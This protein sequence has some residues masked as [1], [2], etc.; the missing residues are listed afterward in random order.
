MLVV[1]PRRAKKRV[2]F[3]PFDFLR[4]LVLVLHHVKSGAL[5]D[6]VDRKRV[7]TMCFQTLAGVEN[8]HANERTRRR[9]MRF[10]GIIVNEYDETT[11]RPRDGV[12]GDFLELRQTVLPVPTGRA[13]GAA[14]GLWVP[15][16]VAHE[17]GAIKLLVEFADLNA[18]TFQNF[19]GFFE[20]HWPLPPNSDPQW[21]LDPA[22]V[23]R[24]CYEL[25]WPPQ[26]ANIRIV[27]GTNSEGRDG[28]E[29]PDRGPQPAV[30]SGVSRH[31]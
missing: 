11:I 4:F 17:R 30:R 27:Q 20:C 7:V 25:T 21:A 19:L 18:L 3:R 31:S 12:A 8:S 15:L 22:P 6:V 26:S 14:N 28:A 16:V 5:D 29:Y 13:N 23:G 10:F 9:A 1:S 24:K 2:A